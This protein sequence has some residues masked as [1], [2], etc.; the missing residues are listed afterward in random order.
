MCEQS[1]KFSN[2]SKKLVPKILVTSLEI[3]ADLLVL[4]SNHMLK[5]MHEESD[6][7]IP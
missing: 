6:I 3:E 1:G 2:T 7:T 5:G 4:L